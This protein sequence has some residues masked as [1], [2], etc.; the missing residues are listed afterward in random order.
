MLENMHRIQAKMNQLRNDC[1]MMHRR[2]KSLSKQSFS[3][4][5]DKAT[6][7]KTTTENTFASSLATNLPANNV[8]SAELASLIDKHAKKNHV[9]SD[10]IKQ[11]IGVASG[12][13]PNLTG[14]NGQ[15]GLMQV[16]PELFQSFGYT[17]P[18]DPDQ[19]ISAGTK[20]LAQMLEKNGGNIP[21]ALASYNT[22]PA[23]VGKF[24]GIPP[25]KDT[26]AFV[27]DVIAKIEKK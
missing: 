1:Q 16:K 5:L 27:K 10:L 17:N 9:D 3:Q 7:S 24:G 25:F 11:L 19:N 2:R 13:D 6:N 21:L 8:K 18:F 20:H 26:Q 12:N 14:A 4:E 22:D 23:T 15:L